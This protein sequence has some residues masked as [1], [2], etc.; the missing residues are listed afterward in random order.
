MS[1]ESTVQVRRGGTYLTISAT[2]VDRY[3]AKGFDVVDDSG[4]VVQACTPNDVNVLRQAYEEHIAEIKSLKARIVEL[5]NQL[6]ESKAVKSVKTESV[7][8]AVVEEAEQ[9]TETAPRKRSK[10]N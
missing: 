10:K 5:E 4:N 3:I 8:S 2:S 6:K 7:A 9:P 1:L